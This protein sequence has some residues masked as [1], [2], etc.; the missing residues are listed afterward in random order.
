[1]IKKISLL[2]LLTLAMLLQTNSSFAMLAASVADESDEETKVEA[3]MGPDVVP[4]MELT[5][6]FEECGIGF[7]NENDRKIRLSFI[8]NGVFFLL[9]NGPAG[10]MRK[11]KTSSVLTNLYNPPFNVRAV[12]T[13]TEAELPLVQTAAHPEIDFYH[14][15]IPNGE[16]PSLDQI[17]LFLSQTD[18][19]HFE[20]RGERFMVHCLGGIDR[21]GT[22]LAVWMM[23]NTRYSLD[24]I[25]GH[26]RK[27]KSAAAINSDVQEPFLYTLERCTPLDPETKTRSREV[28]SLLTQPDFEKASKPRAPGKSRDSRCKC[29]LL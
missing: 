17:R 27:M 8:K 2:T 22:M 12:F 21:T 29:V 1:M 23:Y 7:V 3:I 25:I 6:F 16:A 5:T 19:Y 24:A 26:I 9:G 4:S 14:L 10:G 11:P 13:V 18:R 20:E 15:P 28:L